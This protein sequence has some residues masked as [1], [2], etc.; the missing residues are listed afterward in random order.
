MVDLESV[1]DKDDITILRLLV[2]RHL[3]HTGSAAAKRVMDRWDEMLTRF[4]K[5]YPKDYRHALNQ[6]DEEE[7]HAAEAKLMP[8]PA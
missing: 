4:V 8:V 3:A 6:M 2:E 5:V 7:R 1:N